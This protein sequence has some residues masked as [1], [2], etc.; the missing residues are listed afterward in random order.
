M[1]TDFPKFEKQVVI[2]AS[3]GQVWKY[4]TD[5]DLMRS[6]MTEEDLEISTTW[7]VDEPILIRGEHAGF[8]FYNTGVVVQYEPFRLLEYSHLS[9]LSCLAEDSSENYAVIQFNLTDSEA[10]T[11]LKITVENFPT[12]SIYR[13][14]V[15]Y[16]NV[17]IE[18]L[19]KMIE[20]H[21][22]EGFTGNS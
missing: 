19:K 7:Q 3:P 10:K 2:E 12:E 16:W 9:S 18:I 5:V 20:G 4:L 21:S 15:F 8:A 17:T 6:W 14:L 22:P 1:T 13:H 11:I